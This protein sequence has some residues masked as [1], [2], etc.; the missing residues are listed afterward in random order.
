MCVS[1]M[2][3][4]EPSKFAVAAALEGCSTHPDIVVSEPCE[5]VGAKFDFLEFLVGDNF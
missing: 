5:Y 4:N 3:I 2:C 1:R